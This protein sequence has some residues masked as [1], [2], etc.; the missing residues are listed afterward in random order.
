MRTLV[1]RLRLQVELEHVGG[2]SAGLFEE[3]A[4]EIGRLRAAFRFM[5]EDGFIA[6]DA[7]AGFAQ[8]ILDGVERPEI[9]KYLT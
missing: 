4:E 5:A 8:D 7:N 9:T 6:A 1:D 2:F 3:A